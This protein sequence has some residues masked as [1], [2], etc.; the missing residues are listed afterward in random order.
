MDHRGD[1]FSEMFGGAAGLLSSAE[2]MVTRALSLRSDDITVYLDVTLADV[3]NG[4]QKT[5]IIERKVTKDY[6]NM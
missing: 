6:E 5:V 2:A 1:L 4:A 3:Y